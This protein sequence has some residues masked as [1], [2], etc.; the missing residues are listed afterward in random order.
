MNKRKKV[1]CSKCSSLE[2]TRIMALFI[3]HHK[4]IS[5]KT[6]V[7]HIAPEQGLVDFLYSIAGVNCNFVDL[8]PENF[9]FAPGIKKMDLC[10][11]IETIP[12]NSFDLILHSH[13][14]EHIPCNY[15]Y[16]LYHLHRIMKKEGRMVC[17][18]PFL[19]GF[20]DCCTSPDISN[21]KRTKRFGQNDHVRR[22]GSDDLHMT[23]GKIYH[24]KKEYDITQ[25]FAIE[26]LQQYNIPEYTWR[27]YTPSSVLCLTKE[28]YLLV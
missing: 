21:R 17:S 24:L 20:Y 25:V 10:H 22:F 9:P 27:G 16:V 11:D 18:I 14:L 2:R 4:L 15:T 8:H 13:V 12:D 26:E 23:L 6:R 3:N 1:R 5:K 28:D 19:P 7:L